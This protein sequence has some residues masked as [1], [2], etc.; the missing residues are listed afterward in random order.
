MCDS[1]PLSESNDFFFDLSVTVH[2]QVNIIHRTGSIR[3]HIH[4]KQNV[5]KQNTLYTNKI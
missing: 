2:A 4:Y 1:S 3:K 5:Y